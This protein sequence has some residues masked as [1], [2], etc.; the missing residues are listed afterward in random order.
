MKKTIRGFVALLFLLM[1]VPA[2]QANAASTTKFF[3]DGTCQEC[4]STIYTPKDGTVYQLQS[5]TGKINAL[6]SSGSKLWSYKFP[7]STQLLLYGTNQQTKDA[8]GNLY[9]GAM[10][11]DGIYLTS[12]SS[13][14]KLNWKYKVSQGGPGVPVVGKDGTA[15][16]G[17]GNYTDYIGPYTSSTFYA[18]TSTGKKKWSVKLKG[19]GYRSVPTLDSNQNVVFQVPD[20][21][22]VYTYTISSKTGKILSTKKADLYTKFTDKSGNRYAVDYL[23]NTLVA[24][25]KNGKRLWS[26]KAKSEANFDLGYVSTDGIAYITDGDYTRAISKGKQLWE[27]K[28]SGDIVNTKYGLYILQNVINWDTNKGKLV[29]SIL[30]PKKGTTKHSQSLSFYSYQY[31]VHPNGAV[32]VSKNRTIYKVALF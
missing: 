22:T 31:A 12:I 23:K 24:T 6:K 7:S 27:R 15:Y 10:I 1:V 11:S 9:I 26:F 2:M 17:S 25:D 19:D 16:F 3:Q 13:K 32:F 21:E 18:V 28:L 5:E 14:G 8:K 30:D 20:V 4:F 29:I